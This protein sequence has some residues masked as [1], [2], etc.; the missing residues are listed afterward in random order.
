MVVQKVFNND[1]GGKFL[2][3]RILRALSRSV[4]NVATMMMRPLVLSIFMLAREVYTL[5]RIFVQRGG[6]RSDKV[7]YKWAVERRFDTKM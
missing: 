7:S 2:T 4:G 5:P 1:P 3:I 6:V